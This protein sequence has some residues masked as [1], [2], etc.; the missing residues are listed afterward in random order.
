MRRALAWAATLALT[1]VGVLAAHALAYAALGEPAGGAHG[2]LRHAPQAAGALATVAL[3]A[4]ALETR[5]APGR[6]WPFPALALGAFA[7]QE[8]V[9]RLWHTGELP[10]LATTPVFLLGLA[11]QVPV[12]LAVWLLA[13]RLVAVAPRPRRVPPALPALLL[14]LPAVPVAAPPAAPRVRRADRGPPRAS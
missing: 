12:A 8:H 11:L 2:Y 10:W 13:R 7:C 14:P 6:A 4:L 1:A 9:E 3:L 5:G